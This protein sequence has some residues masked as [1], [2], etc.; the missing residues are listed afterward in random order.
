MFAGSDLYLCWNRQ[1]F[2]PKLYDYF[3]SD[4]SPFI[5]LNRDRKFTASQSS[6]IDTYTQHTRG[7][8]HRTPIHMYK[9]MHDR[10]TE[11]TQHLI[12]RH[13]NQ[14]HVTYMCAYVHTQ[15]PLHN[16]TLSGLKTFCHSEEASGKGEKRSHSFFCSR[17]NT[18][19]VIAME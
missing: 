16:V 2:N 6:E 7:H 14:K 8:T 18:E 1:Q 3:Y 13:I 9:C 10:H 11:H 15:S 17:Y 12:L 4:K 5:M 19:N